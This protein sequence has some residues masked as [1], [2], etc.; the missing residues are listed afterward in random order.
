M[1]CIKKKYFIH[2]KNYFRIS[3]YFPK[4]CTH[5]Q[6]YNT[7][8]IHNHLKIQSIC[9]YDYMSLHKY[10]NDTWTA[11]HY[12]IYFPN[13]L[14]AARIMIKFNKY[15]NIFILQYQHIIVFVMILTLY[16]THKKIIVVIIF[17]YGFSYHISR[18]ICES[19]YEKVKFNT[20]LCHKRS[21]FSSVIYKSKIKIWKIL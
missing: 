15:H 18:T 8:K 11:S 4:I 3:T 7:H 5:T 21:Y 9:Y 1:L 14:C 16:N 17:V 20:Q 12:C 13:H 10:N 6:P 2:T 19:T